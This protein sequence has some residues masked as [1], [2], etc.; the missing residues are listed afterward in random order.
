MSNKGNLKV[1]FKVPLKTGDT[2]T[3]T[4]GCR[5]NNPDICKNNDIP[6]VCAFMSEDGMC[7]A[8]SKTWKRNFL[9]LSSEGYNET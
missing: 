7:R 4:V 9:K 3:T 8:P 1:G 5:A 2:E 6:D